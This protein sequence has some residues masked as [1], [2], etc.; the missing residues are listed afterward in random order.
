MGGFLGLLLGASV[1][2]MF[3]LVDLIVYNGLIKLIYQ[4][5]KHIVSPTNDTVVRALHISSQLSQDYSQEHNM[6]Q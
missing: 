5:K 2:T 1:L 6:F 3:E 4:K